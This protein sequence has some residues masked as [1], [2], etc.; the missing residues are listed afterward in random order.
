MICAAIFPPLPG[1]GAGADDRPWGAGAMLD[2][3]ALAGR[4]ALRLEDKEL[5]RL[6]AGKRFFTMNE[7]AL[8]S[9]QGRIHSSHFKGLICACQGIS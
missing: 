7:K 9:G 4:P 8:P 3:M 6:G 5:K 1:I 2:S